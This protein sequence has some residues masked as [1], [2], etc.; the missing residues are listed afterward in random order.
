MVSLGQSNDKL[1]EIL[2][3]LTEVET[4][5]LNPRSLLPDSSDEDAEA[6]PSDAA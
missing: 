6:E 1:V 3:G 5:F 4:L 2:A